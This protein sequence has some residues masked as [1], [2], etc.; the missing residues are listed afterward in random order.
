M[1]ENYPNV[2]AELAPERF[3]HDTRRAE[4][5]NM[6]YKYI[7]VTNQYRNS[8]IP[9]FILCKRNF[10]EIGP[11]ESVFFYNKKDPEK[12]KNNNTISYRVTLG[13]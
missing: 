9:Q 12:R 2:W 1:D 10:F 7:K 13:I 6:L 5:I 8:T 11:N 4:M 3:K